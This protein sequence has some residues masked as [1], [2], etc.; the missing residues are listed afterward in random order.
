MIF[1]L[2]IRHVGSKA[3]RILAEHYRNLRNLSKADESEIVS[4][5]TIGQTIADSVV[6][7][8]NNEEVHDLLDELEKAG[9][10]FDYLGLKM[11]SSRLL[12][13]PLKVRQLS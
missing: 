8:F 1:G 4:L 3:A 10:N 2:G 11:R 6:T 9:V 7:Y 5:E 12:T 13:H